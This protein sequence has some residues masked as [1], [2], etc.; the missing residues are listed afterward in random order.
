MK[1]I[2]VISAL[3]AVFCSCSKERFSTPSSEGLFPMTVTVADADDSDDVKAW[4]YFAGNGVYKFRWVNGDLVGA[5][6]SKADVVGGHQF[7]A[8]KNNAK[9]TLSGT[10][11]SDA[12]G[13][14]VLLYPKQS[15]PFTDQGN[16]RQTNYDRANHKIT[17]VLIPYKYTINKPN[18]FN[19]NTLIRI[20]VLSDKENMD[21]ERV[22]MYNPLAAFCFTL[23]NS[24][25][26]NVTGVEI[27][28]SYGEQL[29][30]CCDIDIATP[31]APAVKFLPSP[32]LSKTNANKVAY[33]IILASNETTFKDT[34][35][36]VSLPPT[37]FSHG[38]V[39]KFIDDRGN[40]ALKSSSEVLNVGRNVL[41]N[42]GTID[43]AALDW[44]SA[45][46]LRF[47]NATYVK[48]DNPFR[49]GV[50]T[51]VNAVNTQTYALK[52][53]S[54]NVNIKT[55]CPTGGEI[56]WYNN[57]FNIKGTGGYLEVPAIP[58]KVLKNIWLRLSSTGGTNG[59]PCIVRS[60]DGW[61]LNKDNVF[62]EGSANANIWAG[63]KSFGWYK[64][65]KNCFE[66]GQSYKIY[67]T[68][69]SEGM[70]IENLILFYDSVSE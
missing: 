32:F 7:T 15:N 9:A 51:T 17:Q 19:S 27:F 64:S 14:V 22:I 3:L 70:K 56:G 31:T 34:T 42:L 41:K 1:K 49:E 48:S 59:C 5:F 8:T 53:G 50:I 30:G 47:L 10:I 37:N 13:E 58:G 25:S 45:I 33:D 29:A 54:G 38:L 69:S 23:R 55:F 36:C 61:Y 28:G 18:D 63:K 57:G 20:G 67:L 66:A 6:D 39:L 35:Y 62:E 26:H 16:N 68:E 40:V 46:D 12:T 65:W 43:V 4:T 24:S 2:I 52:D 44:H 21:S 60:S 11:C